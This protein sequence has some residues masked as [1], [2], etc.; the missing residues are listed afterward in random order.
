MNT[1]KNIT[2]CTFDLLSHAFMQGLHM[3]D[4][5]GTVSVFLFTFRSQVPHFL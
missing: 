5:T 3:I 2:H 4:F 1:G